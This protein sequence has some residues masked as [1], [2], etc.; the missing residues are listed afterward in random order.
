MLIKFYDKDGFV[1]KAVEALTF[2]FLGNSLQ[3]KLDPE[4]DTQYLI[5]GLIEIYSNY[6]EKIQAFDENGL[7]V[8]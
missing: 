4:N 8:E 6:G 5:N 2:N 1:V 7:I 3:V